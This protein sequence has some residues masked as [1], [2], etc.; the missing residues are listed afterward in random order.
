MSVDYVGVYGGVLLTVG[1]T[2][3]PLG[4]EISLVVVYDV[5]MEESPAAV[6]ALQGAVLASRQLILRVRGL[7]QVYLE[8]P[9]LSGPLAADGTVQAANCLLV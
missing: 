3:G 9:Q 1:A 7:V 8:F 6:D 4:A 5:S 2:V